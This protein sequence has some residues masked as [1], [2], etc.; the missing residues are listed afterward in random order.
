MWR[1]GQWP[2]EQRATLRA[3]ASLRASY[4]KFSLADFISNPLCDVL[5]FCRPAESLLAEENQIFKAHL[6]PNG[7]VIIVLEHTVEIDV[8]SN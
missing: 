5:H 6:F 2:R 1:V 4:C 7:A 8:C 3:A